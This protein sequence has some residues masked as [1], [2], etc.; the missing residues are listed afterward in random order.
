MPFILIK[1]IIQ[2]MAIAG[3]LMR[4]PSS[5]AV[6]NSFGK[7]RPKF[8]RILPKYPDQ[9]IETALSAKVYSKIKSQPMTQAQNSPK[10]T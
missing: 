5:G 10:A 8:V 2:M 9:P 4:P 7:A 6:M 1:V 3:R